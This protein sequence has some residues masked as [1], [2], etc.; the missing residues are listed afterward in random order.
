MRGWVYVISNAAMGGLVKVGFSMQDPAI[1]ARELAGTGV[2]HPY[3]VV[4]DALC[5]EPRKVERRAHE[6]LV[7]HH[8]AKEWFRCDTEV[9]IAAV[10]DAIGKEYLLLERRTAAAPDV[11]ALPDAEMAYQLY[12]D[13]CLGG[14]FGIAAG[15]L[16]RA[17]ELGH[18]SALQEIVDA[19]VDGDGS[20]IARHLAGEDV[21]LWKSRIFARAS[22]IASSGPEGDLCGLAQCY[23]DGWGVARD[24]HR[25]LAL[26]EEAAERG[27]PG[28]MFQAYRLLWRSPE[29]DSRRIDALKWLRRHR[30]DWA[31]ER[32]S[33]IYEVG[34]AVPRDLQ[35]ALA[36]AVTIRDPER[37]K[38]RVEAVQAASR[39]DRPSE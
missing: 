5:I 1:R 34:D 28:A 25:A 29:F 23:L 26:Y 31:I 9:A 11:E 20:D 39:R 6:L 37:R 38:K 24:V 17:A 27:D 2:P 7:A 3:E 36:Y 4:Y 13:A 18:F 8:E 12:E 33:E 10:K 32:L 30:S 15:H 14:Q 35:N 16:R 21:R 19:L 22:E